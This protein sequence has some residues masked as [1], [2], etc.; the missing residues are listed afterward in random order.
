[1]KKIVLIVSVLYLLF[2]CSGIEKKAGEEVKKVTQ[3]D[4]KQELRQYFKA[5]Y[6]S[7]AVPQIA[8]I[9]LDSLQWV[10]TFYKNNKYVTLWIN[11]SIRL[12]KKG[13]R[14]IHQ[15]S[16]ARNYGLDPQWFAITNLLE[17]KRALD[18]DTVFDGDRFA[19][20]TRLEVLLTYYYMMYGKQLNYGVLEDIDSVTTLPRK[21]FTIDLPAYLYAASQT[22]SVVEKLYDLQPKHAEYRNLQKGLESFLQRSNLSTE[23]IE[24]QNFRID[25]LTAVQQAKKALVVHRYLAENHMNSDSLY[26]KALTKFQQ[27][28]GLKPDSLIGNNTAKAL[29]ISPYW[30]YK[31]LVI[32]LERWRWRGDWPSDYI[33]V[34]IPS[35]KMQLYKEAKM[36]REHRVIV[37][38][39]KN[40]TPEL[41]DTLEYIIA[42]PYWNVPRKISVKEI[43]RKI[44]RDSTYLTRNNYEI[45][46]YSRN[47]VNPD[48]VAWDSVTKK[49]FK[50][51]IRQKGG[52]SNALG[53]VKFIFPN[54]YAIYMHDTPSKYYFSKEI[55]AYSHGCVRV[56]KAVD[57]ASYILTSDGNKYTR[58]SIKKYIEEQK[59]KPMPLNT[60]L[61]IYLYYTTVSADSLGRVVFYKDIYKKDEKIMMA[62][63]NNSV[64]NSNVS[65]H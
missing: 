46:D 5:N 56:Q 47:M 57:L 62:L 32:N 29:S 64:Q 30:Y 21:K 65:I 3:R 39:T 38:K 8:G 13:I 51:L 61:P 20:A 7:I 10:H 54:K 41:I 24:V 17:V 22:D 9:T 40:Q 59:E 25:S 53:L 52:G 55:R 31:Q 58:D 26:F 12:S 60:K 42:Y 16:K 18:K 50:Y 37:G 45:F 1:M 19:N 36:V 35:Y 44:K 23:N 4:Y 6:D 33:Y 14:L 11:D 49:N 2:S 43:L 34:N 63:A 27:E 28:H 15:F 48:S